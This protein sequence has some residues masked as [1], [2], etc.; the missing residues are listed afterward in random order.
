MFGIDGEELF[1]WGR[2]SC[3][4]IDTGLRNSYGEGIYYKLTLG[5]LTLDKLTLG[6]L[7]LD[8]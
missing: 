7:T 2:L 1:N 6:K 3:T 8:K 4:W 5:K